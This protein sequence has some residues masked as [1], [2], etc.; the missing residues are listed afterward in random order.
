MFY[1]ELQAKLASNEL[2]ESQSYHPLLQ[3]GR[4][5]EVKQLYEQ[6]LEWGL[7]SADQTEINRLTNYRLTDAQEHILDRSEE[8]R[9]LII[10]EAHT[11]P[12]HRV[13]TRCLLEGLY[14]RGYR[15]LGLENILALPG[16]AGGKM[17][18]SL[19]NER[20]YPTLTAM[21]GILPSEPEYANMIREA[22]DLGFRIFSYERNKSSESERDKQQA[23]RIIH[24]MS[25]IPATEKVIC[26]GG[27]YHAI[28]KDIPK[29]TGGNYWMA[30]EY[31]QL[32]SDDPLTVYQDALN[33]KIAPMQGPSPYYDALR[34]RFGAADKP[35]VLIDERGEPWRGP[36]D[37][38][39]ID[40]LTVQP[41]LTYDRM[42]SWNSWGCWS[43]ETTDISFAPIELNPKLNEGTP[44]I[45]EVR[46][47][48]ES[49]LA[50]PVFSREVSDITEAVQLVSCKG[51][52]TIKFRSAE[53]N[54]QSTSMAW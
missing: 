54:S 44:Y 46:R 2:R 30:Y 16:N 41:P 26:H 39:P 7:D 3:I 5:E 27:W 14:E 6:E 48:Y 24:Y 33:E 12:E 23:Q 22:A 37:S 4:Y 25:G 19:I 1:G 17:L 35:F 52:Y 38:L 34:K 20:G 53:G 49:D 28:E 42:A 31:K 50:T 45:L 8:H 15:H 40:I 51:A 47:A 32:S 21:S 18:D 43:C 13:F 10:T 11:K 36:G 29:D 9:L